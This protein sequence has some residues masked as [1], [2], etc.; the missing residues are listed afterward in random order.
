MLLNC[1]VLESPLTARR[2]NQ[3]ILKEISPEY[4]LERLMLKLRFHYFGHLMWRADSLEKTQMLGKIEGRRRR[5]LQGM[6][7]SDGM[8]DSM[9]MS[10]SKLREIMRDSPWGRSQTGR[11]DWTT[12]AHFRYSTSRGSREFQSSSASGLSLKPQP[13]CKHSPKE[14]HV[15]CNPQGLGM[16]DKCPS[17]PFSMGGWTM[18]V[19]PSY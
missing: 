7:W 1:G 8:T 18:G 17:F 9:E 19:E 13:D 15:T 5:G 2:S 10:L 12:K 3:S 11:S 6:K 16:A 14:P 4:S